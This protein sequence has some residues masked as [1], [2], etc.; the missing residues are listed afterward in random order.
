M[1]LRIPG[2]RQI[3][4]DCS[5]GSTN[6]YGFTQKVYLYQTKGRTPKFSKRPRVLQIAVNAPQVVQM[7]LLR[8]S[9]P[10]SQCFRHWFGPSIRPLFVEHQEI[11]PRILN[12]AVNTQTVTWLGLLLIRHRLLIAVIANTMVVRWYP[13]HSL[14]CGGSAFG[15]A[16]L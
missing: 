16:R 5:T 10:I 15:E 7:N 14:G 4:T 1:I 8:W 2:S 9:Y 12:W 3:P 11:R 6:R 13:W